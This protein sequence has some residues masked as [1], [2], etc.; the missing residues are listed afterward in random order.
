MN[1][2]L[3]IN[4][5]YTILQKSGNLF[6]AIC[7]AIKR[8]ETPRTEGV[9]AGKQ[10]RFSVGLISSGLQFKHRVQNI[11]PDGRGNTGVGSCLASP[12]GQDPHRQGPGRP[13]QTYLPLP[14][15]DPPPVWPRPPPSPTLP[16][17]P[18][19]TAGLV[20]VCHRVREVAQVAP[21]PPSKEAPAI[22]VTDRLLKS[23][24]VLHK[25]EEEEK[26]VRVC[27]RPCGV[28]AC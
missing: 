21:R 15:S 26:R 9:I 19:S 3:Y 27:A 2:P 10:T 8:P 17:L 13:R 22:W 28:R 7:P 23:M 24:G 11:Q 1:S 4:G 18:H 6:H 20:C 5:T 14:P 16:R 25:E 12:L